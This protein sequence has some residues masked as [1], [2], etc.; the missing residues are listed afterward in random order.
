[1]QC[2][3]TNNSVREWSSITGGW[4]GVGGLGGGRQ[5]KINP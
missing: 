4:V 2:T 5:V 3:G 1:M